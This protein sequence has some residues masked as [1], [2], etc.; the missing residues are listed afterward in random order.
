MTTELRR[1]S[2]DLLLALRLREV[3]GPRIAQAL[4]EVRSHCQETGEGPEEAFGAPRAY[5]EQVADA[6]GVP[7][8]EPFWRDVL[9][10]RTVAY[11]LGGAA[12]GWLLLHGA[13]ALASD[14]WARAPVGALA[15]GLLVLA[16]GALGL[17]RNARADDVRVLDPLTGDDLTPRLPP[18]VLPALL[19][20]A[21]VTVVLA[22]VLGRR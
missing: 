17:V 8:A 1:W 12:G 20:P 9:T 22:A 5:A 18:W 15:L 21:V 16:C 11:G 4:A 13:L 10:W 6:L 2:D 7:P 14:G 3:P 19:A